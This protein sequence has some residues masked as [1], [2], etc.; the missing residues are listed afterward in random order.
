LLPVFDADACP[1]RKKTAKSK[2]ATVFLPLFGAETAATLSRSPASARP[3]FTRS[4]STRI[5]HN[6]VDVENSDL[7]WSWG[8]MRA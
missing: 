1:S 8:K 6:E 7:R 3:S 4:R 2:A 5:L